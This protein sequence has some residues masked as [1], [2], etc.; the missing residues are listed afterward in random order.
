MFALWFDNS[1]HSLGMYRPSPQCS[2]GYLDTVYTVM[3]IK[4]DLIRHWK[5]VGALTRVSL[6]TTRSMML[7]KLGLAISLILMAKIA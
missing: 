2:L 3:D 6:G 7:R 1:S 5:G 4:A